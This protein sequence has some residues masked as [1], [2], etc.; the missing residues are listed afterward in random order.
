L[1]KLEKVDNGS[2][3]QPLR[4]ES[5][6]FVSLVLAGALGIT[7]LGVDTVAQ[8]RSG[9]PYLVTWA[10]DADRVDSD[11]LAV[12]DARQDSTTYGRILNSI[13]VNVLGTFP[14]H[15]QQ[16]FT[17]GTPLFANGFGSSRTF[18]FDLTNAA[19]PKL[20]GEVA[21]GPLAF[22][23]SFERLPNRNVLATMQVK[24]GTFQGPGGLAEFDD[25]GRLLRAS[26]AGV[27]GI[28]SNA[29]RPYGLTVIPGADRVVTASDR[30]GLPPWD[31]DRNR[32][33]D[34]LEGYHVQ[35]WRLGSATPEDD[36]AG[37]AARN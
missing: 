3:R 26:S 7:A 23:H 32:E 25:Q 15:T 17:P 20:L 19:H 35:L 9:S 27:E 28:P 5:M 33:R 24:N 21:D 16:L 34:S 30:M 2:H 6:R 13:P 14:H 29:L 22:P 12:I 1:A 18:R 8:P 31:P 11:F 37:S 36:Y 10:G 4:S